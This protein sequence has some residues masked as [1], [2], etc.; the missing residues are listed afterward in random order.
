[1][2]HAHELKSKIDSNGNVI[3]DFPTNENVINLSR[4]TKKTVESF[5]S[6]NYILGRK[7]VHATVNGVYSRRLKEA[8]RKEFKDFIPDPEKAPGHLFSI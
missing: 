6:D 5:L 4:T 1:M 8:L 2:C 3:L 7:I